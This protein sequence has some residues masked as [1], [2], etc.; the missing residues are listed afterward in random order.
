MTAVWRLAQHLELAAASAGLQA[1][2]WQKLMGR[3]QPWVA[4]SDP[5]AVAKDLKRLTGT[6]S[7]QATQQELMRFLTPKAPVRN[8]SL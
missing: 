4:Q 6:A 8:F 5:G 1:A 3:I 7:L 2:E